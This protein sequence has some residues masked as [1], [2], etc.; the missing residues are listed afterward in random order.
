MKTSLFELWLLVMPMSAITQISPRLN[1][2]YLLFEFSSLLQI[3][4]IPSMWKVRR[5]D[6]FTRRHTSAPQRGAAFFLALALSPS[7]PTMPARALRGLLGEQILARGSEFTPMAIGEVVSV[8]INS[9]LREEVINK[10]P[11]F[12]RVFLFL[13]TKKRKFACEFPLVFSL[14]FSRQYY[15]IDIFCVSPNSRFCFC[16][17]SLILEMSKSFFCLGQIAVKETV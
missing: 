6:L 7:A 17:S 10:K 8:K 16:A 3:R 11:P 4:I 15:G 13:K 1:T 14:R 2:I 5:S 9:S 12:S